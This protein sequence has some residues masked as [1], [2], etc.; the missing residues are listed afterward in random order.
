[1]AATP[2]PP[3]F[4]CLY[5]LMGILFR[6]PV[7]VILITISSSI[8]KSSIS[9]SSLC[10]TISVRLGSANFAFISIN[11]SLIKDS[12]FFSDISIELKYSIFFSNSKYSASILFLSKAHNLCNC[13]SKIA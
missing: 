13:I 6:Y 3:L 7:P 2:L 11:S 5:V 8:I 12:C 1:M 4:C 10:E 9:I